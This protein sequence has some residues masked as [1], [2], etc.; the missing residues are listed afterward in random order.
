TCFQMRQ[1]IK[2]TPEEEEQEQY[3]LSAAWDHTDSPRRKKRKKSW[4]GRARKRALKDQAEQA[5]IDAILA[6]V[7]E[8]GLHSLT[9]WEKRS[10]KK[11]TARQRE[12]D[13]ASRL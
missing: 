8:R 12:Q 13:L 3:D 1:M 6:K 11:A 2:H 4:L 9:W 7:K 5:K 10:L